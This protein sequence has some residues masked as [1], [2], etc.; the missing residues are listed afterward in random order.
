MPKKLSK[1]VE[2]LEEKVIIMPPFT[3]IQAALKLKKIKAKTY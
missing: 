3:A 2:L 1:L